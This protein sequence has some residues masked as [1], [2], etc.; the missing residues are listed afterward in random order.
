V[1]S[2]GNSFHPFNDVDCL[3]DGLQ[4]LDW[5][6]SDYERF[7]VA[8]TAFIAAQRSDTE[9]L[10]RIWVGT[11][12]WL[13]GLNARMLR[14]DPASSRPTGAP[15]LPAVLVFRH[16]LKGQGAAVSGSKQ[17]AKAQRPP[18]ARRTEVA[19]SQVGQGEEDERALLRRSTSTPMPQR[20]FVAYGAAELRDVDGG[21]AAD[22]IMCRFTYKQHQLLH[23][24]MRIVYTDSKS[25]AE[26]G[27]GLRG[28]ARMACM[29]IRCCANVQVCLYCH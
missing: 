28:S 11:G 19:D 18:N 12:T 20:F 15:I 17:S 2:D 22:V 8:A 10:L 5:H 6:F 13:A 1:D 23:D 27:V 4:I 21:T 7:K 25:T 9:F 3:I 14:A 29:G 24:A 16:A 26:P